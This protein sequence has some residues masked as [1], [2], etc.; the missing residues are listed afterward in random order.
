[1]LT[2]RLN[3]PARK[4]T[5]LPL[6]FILAVL[7]GVLMSGCQRSGEN[8]TPEMADGG[9][10]GRM[11][12]REGGMMEGEK[13]MGGM[14]GQEDGMPGWMMSRGM[15]PEMMQDMPVIHQLLV[16]HEKIQRKVEDIPG[17]VQ[18]LTTSQDPEVVRLIRKHVRQM[19]DR[20][21]EGEPIRMMDP[22][23]QEIF[24]HH[25]KIQMKVE[26]VPGGVRVTETSKDPRVVSLIRQHAH[27]AVSE[28]VERGMER[29]MKPTPL[30]EGYRSSL[31]T[32]GATSGKE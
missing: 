12:G 31:G 30:P 21:E 18:T 29:A 14:M 23:F 26:D 13:G 17:G 20:V 5:F 32:T 11:K 15:G 24:R 1:M 27:R 22:L 9:M 8:S 19:K 16:R 2:K 6:P 25:D 28:F 7:T 3:A 4:R 10:M